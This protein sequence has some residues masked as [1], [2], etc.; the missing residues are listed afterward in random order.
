MK[1]LRGY[2][3][4]TERQ[5][6]ALCFYE[7]NDYLLINSILWNNYGEIFTA[8]DV[9]NNDAL[10]V[11]KQAREVGV[12]KRWGWPKPFGDWLYKTYQKRSYQNLSQK[13]FDMRMQQ[14]C[15]DIKS[16]LEIMQPLKNDLLV[17][18]NIRY[19][20]KQ[21][22][23]TVGARIKLKGFNSTSTNIH[24]DSYASKQS[25]FLRYEI[26]VPKGTPAIVVADLA[27]YLRNEQDEVILPPIECKITDV[28]QGDSENC[29]GVIK[30]QFEKILKV[31]LDKHK[32]ALKNIKICEREK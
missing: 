16:I 13:T 14:A 3:E 4:I 25:K 12:E 8:L 28:L 27:E 5:I 23:Y 31:D 29:N 19:D 18:R 2:P 15:E 6:E 7:T 21:E 32:S 11:M 9:I 30:M 1:K 10:C 20:N 22:K 17:Y 26:F 24:H